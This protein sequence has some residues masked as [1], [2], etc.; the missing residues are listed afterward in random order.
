MNDDYKRLRSQADRIWH[1]FNDDVDSRSAAAGIE[2]NVREVVE[3]FERQREP[4]SIED[5]IKTVIQQ[6][7]NLRETGPE[8]IDFGDIDEIVDQYEDL[9]RDLRDLE[10]Y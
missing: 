4:R 7:K 8:T 9:R 5:R 1:R 3:D 6:L 10:N 2:R